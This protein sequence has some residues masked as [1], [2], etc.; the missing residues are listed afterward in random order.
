MPPNTHYVYFSENWFSFFDFFF[1]MFWINRT[2]RDFSLYSSLSIQWIHRCW[3]SE[4]LCWS[5]EETWH[6]HR[7]HIT[8]KDS[9]RKRDCF[10]MFVSPKANSIFLQKYTGQQG[11]KP[12]LHWEKCLREDGK[13][14]YVDTQFSSQM[15]EFHVVNTEMQTQ[16][17]I[18]AAPLLLFMHISHIII[19]KDRW[20]V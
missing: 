9:V 13:P 19:H 15:E 20:G 14:G 1:L 11:L 16:Q 8:I 5:S 12:A 10:F 17:T 4:I 3:F 6:T 18:G 2:K 7:A